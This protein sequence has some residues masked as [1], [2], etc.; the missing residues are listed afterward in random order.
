MA[1]KT[2]FD[3]ASE[4]Y[5]LE[6]KGLLS[7]DSDTLAA[8]ELTALWKRSHHLV[9]NNAA[10]VTAR[11][12]LVAHWIGTGIKVRW[13]NKKMQ[14][15]WDKFA[16]NPSVDGWGDL[17][18]LE[19]LWASG[20]FESGEVFSRMLLKKRADM[21]IPLQL[22][23]ME[24]EQLDPTYHTPNNV[25][26]GIQFDEWGRPLKYH[27]WKRMP[28][29]QLG[30]ITT[31]RVP[32]DASD[33]LHIFCRD[34]PGQWRGIPKLAAAILPI[35]ELDETT[36]ATLVRQKMAQ[37][38]GWIIKKI[39]SGA[40]PLLG[41]ITEAPNS[42]E[43]ETVEHSIQQI[44]PGGVHYLNEDEEFEFAAIDDIGGNLVVLLK[45]QW[46]MIASALD[47]TY[48][49]MTGDLSEVNFSSIRA[50]LIEFRRRVA[51]T[52]QMVFVVQGL[53]PLTERFKELAGLYES[54]A[55]REATCKFIFPKT[56]WVDPVK[57]AQAD[58]LEIRSGLA[59]LQT[60]LDER[61]VEDMEEHL[62]QIAKEQGLDIILDSNPKHNTFEKTQVTTGE[63][64][65]P[66][67]KPK[68][69]PAAKTKTKEKK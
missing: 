63:E 42:G 27:F 62:L 68:P 43:E 66:V 47:L 55:M 33:V 60:K 23:T 65:E 20:Y 22:Q 38:V 15:L 44:T 16:A 32:V 7:G 5:R 48:E 21:K 57:D 51:L 8:R 2:A 24:A 53:R 25:R 49:Q 58:L 3:G 13:S 4:S 18:S 28:S 40:M 46:H 12:R 67:K 1:K 29:S 61:G 64:S 6:Q 54:A 37:A 30:S 9:R 41:T 56:E 17:N 10:A 35:Y 19:V 52:Q 69:A 11:N 34:R 50:G 14:K 36:D 31:E 59:T 39:R 26:Y 45:N